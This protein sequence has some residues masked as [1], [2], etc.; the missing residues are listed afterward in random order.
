M[1]QITP[2][3]AISENDITFDFVRAS[4]PGG[5][6]VNKVATAVQLRYHT[7]E[8]PASVL[9]RLKKLAGKRITASGEVIIQASRF[10]SRERN[11][12]DALVRLVALVRE[13]A[14]KPKHRRKTRPTLASRERT[15][16]AKQHRSRLKRSRQRVSKTD[17]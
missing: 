7:K 8:L 2:D 1:I 15:L 5:Q 11:R 14:Q 3:I 4:G 13:A 10:K 9:A 6:H 17:Y 16:A 12:Q